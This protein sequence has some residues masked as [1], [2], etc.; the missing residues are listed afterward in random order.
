M[1]LNC[2]TNKARYF[3]LA[4]VLLWLAPTEAR[5]PMYTRASLAGGISIEYPTHWFVIGAEQSKNL[6]LSGSAAAELAGNEIDTNKVRL[7]SVNASPAPTGAM[8]GLSL[9]TPAELSQT[10][11]VGVTEGDLRFAAEEFR[12]SMEAAEP[13]SGIKVLEVQSVTTERFGQE[14]ALVFRYRRASQKG[15]S[16]WQVTQ[17]KIPHN[18]RLIELTLSYR[19]SDQ[20]VWRP[21]L[22][23]VKRSLTY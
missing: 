15:P 23:H 21:I 14:L 5:E 18:D 2:L 11:L 16:P 7:F 1:S 12:K 10:D 19:E 4:L 17:Y 3:A 8:I 9:T 20:W 13:F 6:V 22:E